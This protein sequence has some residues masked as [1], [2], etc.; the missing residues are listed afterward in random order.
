MQNPLH[1]LSSAA[2]CRKPL[3]A[4]GRLILAALL[5]ALSGCVSLETAAPVS[6]P[7]GSGPLAEG[8]ALYVG[9]CAKCH[10][11][12][13]VLDYSAAEWATIMP[14]MAE[15]TKLT[16]RETAAVTAYV[17]SVLQSAAR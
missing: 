6:G 15:R 8:R 2:G 11:V 9:R 5:A 1:W 7:P 4:P 13:P 14:D 12:E 17:A 10:A 3:P 16:A